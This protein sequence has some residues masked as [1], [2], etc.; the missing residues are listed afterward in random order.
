MTVIDKRATPL[1]ITFGD[2]AIGEAFQ[3][4]QGRVCIKTDLS[5]A[6]R[7][8]EC[9]GVWYSDYSHDVDEFIIPLEVT[10]TIEREGSRK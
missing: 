10:Y 5:A 2:L 1:T 9:D 3:D 6:M 4:E 8:N 7:Y